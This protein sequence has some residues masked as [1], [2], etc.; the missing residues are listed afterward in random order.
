MAAAGGETDG[1]AGGRGATGEPFTPGSLAPLRRSPMAN[2][3]FLLWQLLRAHYERPGGG[4]QVWSAGDSWPQ[5]SMPP[6]AWSSPDPLS[7]KRHLR[8][9]ASQ[10]SFAWPCPPSLNKAFDPWGKEALD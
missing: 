9:V 5:P 3:H 8:A 4:T 1:E 7:L 2:R 10:E 6:A